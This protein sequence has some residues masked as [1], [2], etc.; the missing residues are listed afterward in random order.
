MQIL[1]TKDEVRR[2]VRQARRE[3][4]TVGFVP[5]M[6]YL[7]EGHLA[8]MRKA[9][10]DN[11]L[12]VVSIF[13]NPTQFGPNEDYASYPRDLARDA[14]LAASAGVDI[15]FAP[16]VSEMYPRGFSTI[17]DIQ[18]LGD[19]LCGAKRPGH[20]RGVCT[21]VTKLFNIVQPDRAYFGQKDAQQAR[22]IRQ[23]TA[24]LDLPIEVRVLP[25]VREADGLAMSSRN[26]YLTPREREA[27]LVLNWSL[28]RARDLVQSGE[29]EAAVIAEAI[30]AMIEA[31]PLAR[32]D[33]VSVVSGDTLEPVQR[34]DGPILIAVAV[35]IGK[36]RLIDNL[37]L[38]V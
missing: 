19:Y 11:D 15:I 24:D 34:L 33:Y 14:E 30:T 21:V 25:T 27:A 28:V 1:K 2:A 10:E 20:F 8:L 13:V 17:V 22:V 36:T 9:G 5:T 4:K 26:T 38:E 32:I 23:I 29:Q 37:T 12:V 35:F 6:G 16:E 7:H 18:R 3:G 31:E